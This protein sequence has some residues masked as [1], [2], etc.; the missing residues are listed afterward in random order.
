MWAKN[1]QFGFTIIEL[2]I[3]IVIIAILAVIT[4]TAFNG[5][6]TRA[7]LSAVAADFSNNNKTI[8]MIS[9]MGGSSIPTTVDVLQSS[10]KPTASGGIYNLSS[11]CSSSQKYVLAVEMTTGDKYYS[12]NGA[13]SVQDNAINVTDACTSLG[14]SSAFRIF[15]GM[16]SSPCAPE[17]GSCTFSGTASVA[18]GSLAQ[19]RFTAK[20]GLTSPVSCNNTTFGDPSPG[21]SKACY[22]LNY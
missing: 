18:F 7:R 16:S 4:I 8:K 15:L 22:I 19:G 14:I 1:R 10:T 6:Q 21:F 11:Y 17:T 20:S 13:P 9:A 12:L 3:V 5:V 2:L